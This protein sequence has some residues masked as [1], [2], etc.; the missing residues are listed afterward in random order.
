[1]KK[2]HSGGVSVDK[3]DSSVKDAVNWLVNSGIQNMDA[4]KRDIYGSFNAWYE[5]DTG[6]YP[7]VY[8]ENTGYMLTMMCYLWDRYGKEEYLKRG[9]L[10]GDWLLNMVHESNGGFRCLY[11]LNPS[12]FDFKKEQMYAFDNGIILNGLVN[13]YRATKEEKYLVAAVTVADWLVYSAQKPSGAFYPIYQLV[14]GKFF[15]SDKEWSTISGSYH[16][17][18]AIGLLNL[19]DL[20]HKKKYLDSAIKICDFALSCQNASGRYIS[21]LSRGGTNAHPHCYSGEGLWVAGTVLE[22]E[23]YLE[24]SAR[25]VQ[26]LLD[27]QSEDGFVPRLFLD[28]RP[29]YNERL[30]II[31]QTLRLSMIHMSEKRVPLSNKNKIE[32]L[33]S[34]IIRYQARDAKDAKADGGFYFGKSSKGDREMPHVNLWVSAFAIQALN[35]YM[36]YSAGKFKLKPFLIV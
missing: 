11:P 19:Y 36:D 3:V 30:D 2:T 25:G 17:K 14:D 20:S 10:A 21:Y 23:D 8:S 12:R 18:I 9:K 31:S 27:M 33:L 28:D 22:R 15:E 13:L 24:S 1:M 16:V 7:F 34:H 5:Q 6:I 4:G 29:I 32:L 26:W 35:A